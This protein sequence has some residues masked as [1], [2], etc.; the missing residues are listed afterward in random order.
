MLRKPNS[1]PAGDTVIQDPIM[2]PFFISKSQSGGYTVY[3]RVTKGTNN[4]E[5]IQTI[6]YP[7]TF[8]HA[9]KTVANEKLNTGMSKTYTI[10]EYL[11]RWESISKEMLTMTTIDI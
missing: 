10:K 2:E 11:N 7:A 5:Y 3:K 1:I 8:N 6:C 9:L 4:T